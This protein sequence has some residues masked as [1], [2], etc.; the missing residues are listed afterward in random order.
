[1]RKLALAL[2]LL[3]AGGIFVANTAVFAGDDAMKKCE[4]E[5]DAAKKEE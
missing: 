4:E 1:M 2:A 5:K 3:I